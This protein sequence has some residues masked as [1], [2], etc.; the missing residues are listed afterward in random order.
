MKD[1]QKRIQQQTQK[2]NKAQSSQ[3]TP[4]R[5]GKEKPSNPKDKFKLDTS[6]TVRN[7]LIIAFLVILLIPTGALGIFSY[8]SA[9]G[10][11]TDQIMNNTEEKI[12]AVNY[13]LSQLIQT[14]FEDLEYLSSTVKGSMVDGWASPDVR[15][16]IDPVKAVKKEYD[17]VQY[18]ESGG[19]LLNSPQQDFADGFDPRERDWYIDAMNNRGE[20]FVGNA[21]VAQDGKIIVVPSTAAQDG[22]G[23]VSIVLSLDNLSNEVGSISIG[24]NGYVTILDQDYKY[25]A[26]PTIEAGTE[27]DPDLVEDLQKSPAGQFEY[28]S[29]DGTQMQAVYLTNPETGWTVMGTIDMDEIASASQGIYIT[30]IVIIGIAIVFG[31]AL[32]LWITNSINNPLRKLMSATEAIANGDLRQE[33]SVTSNDEFG[34]LSKA[35]NQ[36][37]ANLRHLIGQ[38][39]SNSEEVATTSEELSASAEQTQNTAHHISSSVQEISSGADVQVNSAIQ[40]TESAS[41]ISKGMEQASSSI[42]HVTQLTNSTNEKANSGN[43]VVTKT[44]KQM[45]VIQQ[46]VTDTASVVHSLGEKSNE[47]TN[48]VTLITDIADQTNLL[49]LNASIEA[50]RAGEQGKG[51]AVVAEEVKKLAEQ[52]GE[53]AGQIRDIIDE[54]QTQA[55]K[56]VVSIENGTKVVDEGIN[57]V[58]MTGDVF[59]EIVHSIEQ[60]ANEAMD[61]STIV[62]Q[63][64]TNAQGMVEKAENVANIAQQSASNTQSVAAATEEQTASMEEVS[65][66]AETLNQMAQSLQK[67]ISKFKV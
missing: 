25:V 23:V 5:T 58:N 29:D 49:A 13:D 10:E 30:T 28:T 35:V 44:V 65:A 39:H 9:D 17:H 51:F 61:V 12:D 15:M 14:T 54:V 37:A 22:S 7:R 20:F 6:M 57:M 21:F 33:V 4:P 31:I 38:V 26:H 19:M 8:Q 36:M 67:V 24:E 1:L 3:D 41:E 62:K 63:V 47:I 40:F 32:M 60:V 34:M 27:A 46:T 43:K 64:N 50:A 66:S 42:Q 2:G 52:S 45:N 11:I 16:I 53:A 55:D 18:A 56:S 48:I 59:N